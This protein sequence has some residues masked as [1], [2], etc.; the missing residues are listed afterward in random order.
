[1]HRIPRSVVLIATV[2]AAGT[3]TSC[4]GASAPAPKANGGSGTTSSTSTTTASPSATPSSPP[5]TTASTATPRTARQLKR[6]LLTLDDLPSGFAVERDSGDG[7]APRVSSKNPRCAPFV[8]LS[9]A[10]TPPGST[11]SAEVSFSAGQGGPLIDEGID[12]LGSA[13][14][15]AALQA[16][17]KA[18]VTACPTVTLFVPDA[19]TSTVAVRSVKPPASG[20][21]PF[22]VRMTATS[23]PLEGFEIVMVTTGVRDTILSLDFVAATPDDIDGATGVS[24]DKATAILDPGGT[25][26]S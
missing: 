8:K 11:A 2:A 16:K 13:A 10:D 18:A 21:R 5:S 22:A 6:A 17:I 14:K 15:V 1:M 9:N 23:G 24:V 25:A 12:A 7:S 19:G 4:S 26:T 3:L 20:D